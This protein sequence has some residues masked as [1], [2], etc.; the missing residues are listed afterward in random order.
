MHC[1]RFYY[2][3]VHHNLH[4]I[5]IAVVPQPQVPIALSTREEKYIFRP[6]VLTDFKHHSVRW[7]RSDHNI[8]S[9][10]ELHCIIYAPDNGQTRAIVSFYYHK[11]LSNEHSCRAP[12]VRSCKVLCVVPRTATTRCMPFS[13]LSC[14][15]PT[16]NCP[17]PVSTS[18][19]FLFVFF[20]VRYIFSTCAIT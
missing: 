11:M 3:L 15:L 12:C 20:S 16:L 2:S 1:F 5:R 9:R 7:V 14:S 10:R 6:I 19:V 8:K 17:F 4:G 18:T 13:A